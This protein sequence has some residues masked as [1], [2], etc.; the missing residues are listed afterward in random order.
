MVRTKLKKGMSAL[1]LFATF[2]GVNAYTLVLFP[3]TVNAQ[4]ISPRSGSQAEAAIFG[5]TPQDGAD[6]AA[7]AILKATVAAGATCSINLILAN[8]LKSFFTERIAQVAEEEVESRARSL[9]KVPV[10]AP[11]ANEQLRLLTGKEVSAF[12]IWGHPV[13]PSWDA[14]GYCITNVMIDH[15]TRATV[16]WI[17]S[18]FEGNPAFIENPEQFFTDVAD[19][20]AGIFLE[21]LSDGA[22]CEQFDVDIKIGLINDHTRRYGR[23]PYNSKCTLSDIVENVE[24]FV[25]GNFEEGGWTGWFS[26]TQ[27][28]AN[29]PYGSYLMAERQLSDRISYRNNLLT[30]D[31]TWG[32]GFLSF[33]DKETG[34]VT[35]PG[36]VIESQLNERLGSGTRRIEMADEFDEIV[37]EL[38]NQLVKM[39]LNELLESND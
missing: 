23:N 18:G 14:I 38:V 17:R 15:I 11:I 10:D 30:L 37:T 9:D 28:P 19:I 1:L 39:A 25:E 16:E 12:K 36:K 13:A 34:E 32:N 4:E 35:T 24:G 33:K 6:A 21:E 20:E 22:L 3:Y 31:L 8:G 7:E 5:S 27:D 29:N 26:L 2:V